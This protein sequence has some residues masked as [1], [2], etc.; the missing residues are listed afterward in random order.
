MWLLKGILFFLR[1]NKGKFLS[2]ID[3]QR[4]F[5]IEFK[6]AKNPDVLKVYVGAR[7]DTAGSP[8]GFLV[9]ISIWIGSL[10]LNRP[11]F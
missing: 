9:L 11:M 5:N 1:N 3:Y 10:T 6:G 4:S 2:I 7:E 8:S